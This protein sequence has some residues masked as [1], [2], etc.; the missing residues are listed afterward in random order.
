MIRWTESVDLSST[1]VRTFGP[2]VCAR[3]GEPAE[4]L[5]SV[6]L[7]PKM[8]PWVWVCAAAIG[9]A[10][11][12]A[13][14]VLAV[15]PVAFFAAIVDRQV[16]KPMKVPGWPYC[17]R[18][19]ALHRVYVIGTAA[20]MLGLV[21][22]VLGFAVLLRGI[23]QGTSGAPSGKTVALMGA[24]SLLAL[25]GAVTRPWFS[26][27]KLAGAHVSRDHRL[28]RVVAHGRFAA[29]VRERLA[30][31]AGPRDVPDPLQVLPRG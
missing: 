2:R 19:F 5:R 16:R 7:R 11:G 18:C 27:P 21:A 31:G 23:L 22:Y 8:P 24:G 29:H 14:G 3:H 9:G 20:V 26:W 30:A 15:V 6:T 17:P 1:W 28:V 25:A 4:A 13:C 12:F 10:L